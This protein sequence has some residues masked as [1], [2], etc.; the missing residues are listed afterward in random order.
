[1]RLLSAVL[2]A[3]PTYNAVSIL[4]LLQIA[5]LLM[6]QLLFL[7]FGNK[8]KACQEKYLYITV[9]YLDFAVIE[10]S[11][12]PV[13]PILNGPNGMFCRLWIGHSRGVLYR[14]LLFNDFYALLTIYKYI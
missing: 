8:Q 2:W 10:L 7:L 14:P 11:G 5:F 4:L 9:I 6:T 1:M 13:L 3:N 12:W